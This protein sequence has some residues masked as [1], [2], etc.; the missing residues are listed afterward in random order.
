M[1]FFTADQHFYHENILGL[2]NRPFTGMDEMNTYLVQRWNEM[3]DEDDI[4]YHLG[5]F[6]LE[7]AEY[8]DRIFKQLN[9]RI[10]VLGNHTHHDRRWLPANFGL[11]DFESGSGWAVEILPP[12][13]RLSFRDYTLERGNLNLVLCHFPMAIW[14]SKHYD[15]VHLHGHSHGNY[16]RDNELVFDVGVDVQDYLPV[17]LDEI[18]RLALNRKRTIVPVGERNNGSE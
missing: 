5:D 7:T 2:A 14:E 9:G 11:S 1:I 17:S 6:T 16:H 15:A 8:A 13:Q 4:I 12:L 18:L 3:V 10:K